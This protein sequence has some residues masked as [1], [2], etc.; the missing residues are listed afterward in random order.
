MAFIE[1]DFA[2]GG[3]GTELSYVDSEHSTNKNQTQ[4]VTIDTSKDYVLAFSIQMDSNYTAS[5]M[6]MIPIKKGVVGSIL[7]DGSSFVPTVSLSGSTLSI[8]NTNTQ[9]YSAWILC[10]IK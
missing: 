1:M 4:T 7:N 8:T 3:G 2:S 6:S 10:E 9:H 5:L